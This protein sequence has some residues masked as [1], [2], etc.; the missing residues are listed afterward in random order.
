MYYFNRLVDQFGG[1]EDVF[2]CILLGFALLLANSFI[3]NNKKRFVTSTISSLFLTAE[4][5]SLYL[6]QTFIGYQFYLHTNLRG[7]KGM[8]SLFVLQI[9]ITVLLFIGLVVLFQSAHFLWIKF[10]QRIKKSD[11]IYRN[12]KI[13]MISLVLI[14][15]VHG[16]FIKDTSTLLP[17]LAADNSG[18]FNDV[19]A[20][21]GMSD[22]VTPKNL[23]C[24]VGKN[25]IAISMESLENGF[26]HEKYAAINGNLR[27]LK[28]NWNFVQM[29]Q[30][31]GSNWTSGSLYT[32]LT[33]FPAYFGVYGNS[34][35]QTAYHSNIS[36]VSHTLKKAGY[37]L[38]YI[39]GN[40]DGGG[41]KEMLGIL[42]FDKIIDK[43][44]APKT[45]FES[46]FG[47][48]D[49]EVF[50]AAKAEL[51]RLSESKQPFGLFISTTDTHFPD[52]FYDERMEAVISKQ[53]SNFE[54][55]IATLN[56]LV[57]DF[58]DFIEQN[59]LE[60]NTVLFLYPDHLKMGNPSLLEG[61]GNRS[62]Y[63]ITNSNNIKLNNKYNYQ[64]DL[65][66]ILLQGAEVEHNMKFLTDYLPSDKDQYI[67]DNTLSLTEINTNGIVNSEIEPLT[68]V[69]STQSH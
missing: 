52:G 58:M 55:T 14:H 61:T 44:N 36:S 5:F 9:V 28:E 59:N 45:E 4:V 12:R 46:K 68:V 35:F 65:P 43:K 22:Y 60:E 15:V 34:I 10:K 56:Y 19:L 50:S 30:N 26:L 62:L 2:V 32:S 6:T 37:Q 57:G 13:L 23:K 69:D 11:K 53:K 31:V 39:N 21:H 33:G 63:V 8:E 42:Q 67:R 20:K 49:K 48:R 18:N 38:T 3:K 41:V 16:R 25:I 40:A 29:S 51:K 27:K 66:K 1:G 17:I 24:T 64:I 54:F 47:L 7:I